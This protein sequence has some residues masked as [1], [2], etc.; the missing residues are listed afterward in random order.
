M[1]PHSTGLPM[2]LEAHIALGGNTEA[3]VEHHPLENRLEAHIELEGTEQA[4]MQVLR[5]KLVHNRAALRMPM[6]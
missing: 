4:E 1:V 3:E 5:R 2:F 6:R